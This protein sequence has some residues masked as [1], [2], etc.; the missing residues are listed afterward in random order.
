M[1][2]N[3]KA[4]PWYSTPKAKRKRKGLE[5][6][7]SDEAREKLER[8]AARRGESMSRVVESLILEAKR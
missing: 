3:P 6:T 7:L 1:T 5:V 4:S 8:L 2:G